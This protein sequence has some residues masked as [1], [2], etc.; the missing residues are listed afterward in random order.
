[1][2]LASLAEVKTARA[3]ALIIYLAFYGYGL[4]LLLW[5]SHPDGYDSKKFVDLFLDVYSIPFAIVFVGV[6][7]KKPTNPAMDPMKLV[8]LYGSTIIWNVLIM[9][10]ITHYF[11]GTTTT[12]VSAKGPSVQDLIDQLTLF[13][14]K[15]A[16]LVT[17]ILTYVYASSD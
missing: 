2:S 15:L 10:A 17:G 16:F 13:K 8:L 7:A 1:M 9:I 11:S 14:D 6:V 5:G 4:W 12:S 3:V